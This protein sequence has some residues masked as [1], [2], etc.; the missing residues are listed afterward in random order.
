MFPKTNVMLIRA[1][2]CPF[3]YLYPT[4]HPAGGVQVLQK[5]W[6]LL[7]DDSKAISRIAESNLDA[8]NTV[9]LRPKRLF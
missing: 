4:S 5:A 2:G 1:L 8:L 7:S 3:V 6:D 9:D